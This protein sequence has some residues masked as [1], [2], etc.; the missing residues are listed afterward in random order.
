MREKHPKAR[1]KGDVNDAAELLLKPMRVGNALCKVK[2]VTI[3]AAEYAALLAAQDDLA[4]ILAKRPKS[5]PRSPIDQH[6]DLAA[7]I[8]ARWGTMTIDNLAQECAKTFQ[9]APSRSAIHRFM[10]RYVPPKSAASCEGAQP[11]AKDTP[12]PRN[13]T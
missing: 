5:F 11:P 1:F 8:V 6:E 13:P 3:P 4:R 10:S 9:H 2:V 12:D 7:F